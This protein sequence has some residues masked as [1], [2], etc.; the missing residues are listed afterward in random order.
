MAMM[1]M[2]HHDVGAQQPQQTFPLGRLIWLLRPYA[3][4]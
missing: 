2:G 3:I 1:A 4:T